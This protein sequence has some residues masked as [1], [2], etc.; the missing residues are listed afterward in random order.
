MNHKKSPMLQNSIG[1]DHGQISRRQSLEKNISQAQVNRQ[2]LHRKVFL[3]STSSI[4][5][6]PGVFQSTSGLS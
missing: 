3:A 1:H 6:V 2:L 5:A 4:A